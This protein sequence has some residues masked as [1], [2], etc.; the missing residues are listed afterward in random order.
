MCA[1]T[2]SNELGQGSMDSRVWAA[3]VGEGLSQPAAAASTQLLG[4]EGGQ[5]QAA[6]ASPTTAL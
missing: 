3:A 5:L 6:A 2:A 1:S 4:E